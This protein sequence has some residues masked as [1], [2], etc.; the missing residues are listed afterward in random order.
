MKREFN[1][2]VRD[3]IPQIIENNGEQ[4]FTRVLDDEEYKRELENKIL[5]EYEE[6]LAASGKERVEELADMLEIIKCL[7]KLENSSLEE[8]E[9]VANQ[10]VLKRGSFDKKIF[11]ERTE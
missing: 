8:V 9:E 3:N 11:L 7:A 5:E 1:K 2:L 10:K 6:M 4:A